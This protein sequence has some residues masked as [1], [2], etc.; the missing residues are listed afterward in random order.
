M[1][2]APE[3]LIPL[4]V[5]RE[6]V[7]RCTVAAHGFGWAAI[8]SLNVYLPMYLQGVMGLSPTGSGLSLMV[9]MAALN[10]SAGC[11]SVVL[12]R[13]RHYKRLPIA[14][15]FIALCAMLTMAWRVGD[16]SL[17]TFEILLLLVAAG[18]GPMPSLMIVAMQNVV[19]RHQLGIGVATTVFSRNLCSTML[20][21]ILGAVMLATT[22][23]IDPGAIANGAAGSLASPE[24]IETFRHVFFFVA[25]SLAAAYVAVLLM[26]ER[27]LRTDSPEGT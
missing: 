8:L 1:V 21:A 12:G 24:A 6:P 25:A 9:L 2:T 23:A 15:F 3:P 27:P 11:A 10:F 18:F 20:I 13:V 16:M 26:E 22:S 17:W 4:S 5:L 14:T 7:V 19:P